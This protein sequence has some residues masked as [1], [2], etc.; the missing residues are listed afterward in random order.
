MDINNVIVRDFDPTKDIVNPIFE[1]KIGN[2]ISN[3]YLSELR[4][5]FRKWITVQGRMW[6]RDQSNLSTVLQ[7]MIDKNIDIS[8]SDRNKIVIAFTTD[9]TRKNLG[10]PFG[11]LTGKELERWNNYQPNK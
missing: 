1:I 3:I 7:F 4:N 6:L 2:I 5:M 10:Y 11:T 8:L 9:I